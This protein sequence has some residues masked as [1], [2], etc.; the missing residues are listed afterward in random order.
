MAVIK[1]EVRDK[2]VAQ[3][4][5]EIAFARRHKQ[6]KVA[7]WQ[8]VEDFY[9]GNKKKTDEARA[10][11]DLGQ[12][13]EHVHTLLSKIDN[14]LTF[15]YTKRKDSQ[16]KRVARLNA[17]K[18]AEADRDFWDIKDIAG[19]KQ[20]AIYGR[21]IYFFY[22]DSA[23]KFQTHLE[24]TDVYDFLIDPSAGGLD[25]EKA[26]N[27]GRYGVVK[28]R[29]ELKNNPLYIQT[30]VK[31]LLAG[32]GNNTERPQE[33]VNKQNRVYANKHQSGQ[34]EDTSED[35]FKFWE[36]YTTYEGQRYYLLLSE[37]GAQ[38]IRLEPLKDIFASDMWPC[39]SY[40]AYPDLTEF[41]TPSPSEYV[42]DIIRSQ[43][44]SINQML[45]NAERV[46]RP[47]RIVDIGAIKNLA[48]LKYK[49][50][51]YIKATPGTAATAVKIIETPSIETP[52]KV[53]SQ[54]ESIKGKASGVN[55]AAK[56]VE[57]TDGRA[58]IYEGN[59]A[60]TA[61][62]F[63]LFNKSYSAGY[64]RFGQLFMHGVDEHLTKKMAVEYIGP[65]GIE[66]ER[67]NRSDIFKK[68]DDFG[69]LIESSNA[70]LALSESKK[71]TLSAF[72]S[73]L[74]GQATIANQKV[75]MENLGKVAGA[76]PEEIRQLLDL[77]L[78][79][80]SEIMS[81]AERDIEDLLEG[82]IVKPNRMANA[83]YKQRMVNFMMDNE[84]DMDQEQLRRM[85]QYVR[86]LDEIIVQNTIREANEKAQQTVMAQNGAT[87]PGAK[88]PQ[89]RAPGPAQPLQDVIQQN[90][91]R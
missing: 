52:L 47:Q 66:T 61:D 53:F 12:M 45:D 26:R 77:D 60:N 42:L 65:N 29:Y 48:E 57:D 8:S 51:G 35:K 34:K 44:V 88:P 9:Y 20:M 80:T 91:Q 15:V 76:S 69:M 85:I 89:L 21:A 22:A 39:W 37:T 55:D 43:N 40:A 81:E 7:K 10:N 18:D 17:I 58:T 32:K 4:L 64:K 11:V 1:K 78:Y 68:D 83:A 14:P 49:R 38:A 19:K 3:A 36:W 2:I 62:R 24:N 84:E 75:V 74:V 72:Y 54:L 28:D 33:E 87:G 71:R 63:G 70:E 46:N 86:S 16:L 13:Q 30:E 90:V 27:L 5:T 23:T 56:G 79:G 41:W 25:I 73:A 59:Q 67:I 31:T 82:K 6:G 50:D